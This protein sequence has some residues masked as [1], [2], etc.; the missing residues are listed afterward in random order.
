MEGIE[1]VVVGQRYVGVV[2]DEQCQH[3]IAFFRNCVV[4]RRV[5]LGILQSS[6]TNKIKIKNF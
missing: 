6:N 2:L 4:Q 3:V 5:T 1:S